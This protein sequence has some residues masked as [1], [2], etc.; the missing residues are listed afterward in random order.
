VCGGISIV[1]L[2]GVTLVKYYGIKENLKEVK[3]QL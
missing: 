2:L 3:K 1:A